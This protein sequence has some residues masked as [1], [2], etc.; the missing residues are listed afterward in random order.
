MSHRRHHGEPGPER[1][2]I[3]SRFSRRPYGNNANMNVGYRANNEATSVG[4][5]NVSKPRCPSPKSNPK[6]SYGAKIGG[7][8]S[9]NCKE[10][11]TNFTDA[12]IYG[13]L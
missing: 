11:C 13:N 8:Y 2:S 3:W 1:R 9:Y 6:S 12:N 5:Q 7:D 4:D 10:D